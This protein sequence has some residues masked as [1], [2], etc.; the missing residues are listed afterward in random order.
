MGFILELHMRLETHE[1]Y[2]A[3]EELT[4]EAF[5]NG[6]WGPDEMRI[7]EEHLL[8]HKLRSVSTFVPEL[9][10]VAEVDG[11][12]VGH[13]IYTRSKVVSVEGH[14]VETL[15]FGP[16][17]VLPEYQGRGIG[18]ALM[19][20]TFEIAAELNYRAVLIFGHPDYYPR[21]GFRRASEFNITTSDGDSFDPFMAFPLYDGA[22]D[23]VSGRY[24]ID[25]VYMSL[26][27]ADTLEFDKRFPDK[28]FHI[29]VSIDVMLKRLRPAAR[30]AIRKLE[31]PS[32]N[33]MTNKSQKEFLEL[34]GIEERDL[35]DIR[36]FMN[37]HNLP[38]GE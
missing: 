2:Y 34:D 20:Y 10:Y 24:Y 32:I 5:W 8:V 36:K 26:T 38:W 19:L 18:K 30:A 35:E 33:F 1:D 29:P 13:I 9:D 22:L 4:R 21:V 6:F 11:K 16:L 25:P 14:E 3:V 31:Y 15:T 27:Q 23:G 17:S 12:I 37:E 7:C 28:D